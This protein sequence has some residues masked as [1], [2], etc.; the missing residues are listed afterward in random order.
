MDPLDT[1][2]PVSELLLDDKNP[3]LPE[4][5]QGSDQAAILAYLFEH[6]VLTELAESYISN[7]YFPN[8][9]LLVLP[10]DDNGRRV[11]V[12][13]NRRLGA[14]KY[15][16]RDEVALEA[17]LPEHFTDPPVSRARLDDLMAIPVVELSDRDELSSYLGFR[18]IS[19]LKTW[20]PEAKSRYLFGEVEKARGKGDPDPFYSVGRTVGSN[21]LGV[22]N[23]YHAY[24]TLRVA[25]DELGL[26]E[27]AVKV[28]TGRFGVWT[29][30]LGTA[31]VQS[32]IG[33]SE[34]SRDYEKVRASTDTL[35][36]QELEEVLTDLVPL[37]GERRAVLQDSRDV[38]EYSA[39]IADP[40]AREVLRRYN[41]LDLA[42]EVANGSDFEKRLN[43]TLES[44]AVTIQEVLNGLEVSQD[45]LAIARSITKSSKQ[46]E[47]LVAG[48]ITDSNGEDD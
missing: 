8:E 41:R 16:L 30:L 46:L 26:R 22:R 36:P 40:P 5:V 45:A 1:P 25:R 20:S 23:A 15:L 47:A 48:S 4:R 11:V 24:N 32:Y 44:L 13:G 33:L 9:Q 39:V 38:T 12:E 29:R 35:K 34:I 14:L 7:G 17:G 21:S 10:K 27:L 18:H 6:D 3:R 19:G 28:L 31:N 2:V 37:P 42:A 43:R